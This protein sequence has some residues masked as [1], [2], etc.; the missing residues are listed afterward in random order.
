MVLKA[1]NLSADRYGY[2]YGGG[3]STGSMPKLTV[4]YSH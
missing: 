4:S 2:F 1:G 3:G